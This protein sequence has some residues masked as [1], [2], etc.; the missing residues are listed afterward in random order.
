MHGKKYIGAFFLAALL[1]GGMLAQ[2]PAQE[3]NPKPAAQAAAV[4]HAYRLDYTLTESQGGKKIDSRQYSLYA[5]GEG[6]DRANGSVQIGTRVPVS[7][8]ADGTLDYLSVGTN[9][10]ATLYRRADVG[11]LDT[12]C[13]VS[14]LAPEDAKFSG[15]PVLRTLTINNTM[16]L[17]EGKPTVVGI[18]DDP[19]SNQ[20]FELQVTVTELK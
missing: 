6:Q 11:M 1:A 9:I 7:T 4:A 15:R 13:D 16:P 18:A 8:K 10:R 5:G 3:T 2:A 19:N 12:Y 17:T 14:S 20:E